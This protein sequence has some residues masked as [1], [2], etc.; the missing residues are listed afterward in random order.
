[1]KDFGFERHAPRRLRAAAMGLGLL[2]LAACATVP[3]QTV[4]VPAPE[5]VQILAINDFH[6]SLEV[7]AATTSYTAGGQQLRETLGGAARLGATLAKLREGQASTVT[8]AAGDL[9]GGSPLVSA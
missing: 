8:V 7:P 6:G 1:M 5:A 4:A 2:A 9:I 3:P